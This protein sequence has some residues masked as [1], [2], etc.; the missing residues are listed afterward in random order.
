MENN[1][2]LALKDYLSNYRTRCEPSSPKN[3]AHCCSTLLDNKA[4]QYGDSLV[5]FLLLS[6]K[7]NIHLVLM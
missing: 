5:F 4:Q 2:E 3:F 1:P 7:L 6:K